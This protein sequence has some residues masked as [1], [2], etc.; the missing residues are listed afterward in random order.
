MNKYVHVECGDEGG[1]EW[2]CYLFFNIN[3]FNLCVFL[4]WCLSNINTF[5]CLVN[6]NILCLFKNHHFYLRRYILQWNNLYLYSIW[7]LV[8]NIVHY[9]EGK[10]VISRMSIVV[11][12]IK[13]QWS[14]T[15]EESDELGAIRRSDLVIVK[16]CYG[17]A[18][19]VNR[20]RHG[21][22]QVEA[23][24]KLIISFQIVD[25]WCEI[26]RLWFNYDD[27]WVRVESVCAWL[28]LHNKLNGLSLRPI[29]VYFVLNALHCTIS[30]LQW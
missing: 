27:D 14:V 17:T 9:L 1:F 7:S 24:N 25:A 5:N 11:C 26:R 28:G 15:F 18:F 13:W 4:F 30:I 29:G 22:G 10:S 2:W 20:F 21:E 12:W 8:S 23:A 3:N 16:E 19:R 6:R